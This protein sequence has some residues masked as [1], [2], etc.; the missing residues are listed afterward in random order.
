M[1]LIDTHCH[2]DFSN[3]NYDREE[4]ISR[5]L[6]NN[7]KIINIGTNYQ[8]SQNSINLAKKYPNFVYATIGLHPIYSLLSQKN[9]DKF[10]Y[11]KKAPVGE[12]LRDYEKLI[13]DN[14]KNIVAVGEIG[15]D[16]S[17]IQNKEEEDIQKQVFLEQIKLAKNFN[18]PI[19]IHC[20]NGPSS[21]NEAFAD[22]IKILKE[23]KANKGVVHFFSGNLSQ[24][25]EILDLGLF[26]SFTG[27]ITF[28]SS[29]DKIIKNITIERILLE[30]DSPF[31]SPIPHRGQ[32]NSPLYLKYIA[33]KIAFIKNISF[34]EVAKVTTINAK[35]LFNLE[36]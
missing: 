35:K 1:V 9:Y 26:I 23:T 8:S 17:Y 11:Q 36:R 13:F 24:A 29:Y 3:Y 25:E 22:L 33:Q 19:A 7:I 28:A 14:R 4:I 6:E 34:E 30:T 32:R 18:L 20:R 16:Y 21:S 10:N 2:L 31:V 12:S 5:C 15:L 27:V